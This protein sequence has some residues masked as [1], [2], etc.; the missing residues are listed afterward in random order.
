MTVPAC[1][2][3][4]MLAMMGGDPLDEYGKIE[5]SVRVRASAGSYFSRA[6]PSSSN[7]KTWTISWWLKP[8]RSSQSVGEVLIENYD[9]GQ[10][11]FGIFKVV[12]DSIRVYWAYGG[13]VL[14]DLITTR[15]FR[16]PGAHLNLEVRIDTTQATATDRVRVYIDGQQVT[17]FSTATY[18]AQNA[19]M[20]FNAAG[21][22][23]MGRGTAGN[24]YFDGIYSCMGFVDGAS[25][26]P[27]IF[28]QIHP[29]TG[30]WRP[31]SK[32]AIRAAVAAAGG[33]VRNGWGTNGFFLPFD[34]PT[35]LTT[36]GY[37]RSQSD[38]DTTGNNWA[39]T[40]ISLTAGAAYDSMLDT[41][42]NNFATLNPL[43]GVGSVSKII[44]E[45]NLRIQSSAG[46]SGF[47]Y[48]T[49]PIPTKGQWYFEGTQTS[50]NA[51]GNQIHISLS[52]PTGAELIAYRRTNEALNGVTINSGLVSAFIAA[53]GDVIGFAVDSDTG[54]V[55][56][57]RNGGLAYTSASLA[58][59]GASV[60]FFVSGT[61]IA[62]A[63]FGQ[64]QFAYTPPSGFKSLCT[65]NLP[66]PKIPNPKSAF[67]AVTDTGANIA[68]T[69]ANARAGWTAHIDIIKRRDAAEGWRWVF[70]DDT[71]NHLDSSSTAAKAPVPSFSGTAYVGYSLKVSA[72]NGVA[73]GR[74]TH[75]SGTVDTVVDGLSSARKMVILKNE[76]AGTWYVYHPALTVGKL[77]YLEQT[78]GETTD[79]TINTVTA[80]GFTV[81][82]ALAS[83]TYR[84][85]A[86]ADTDGLLKIGKHTGNASTDGPFDHTGMAP[87]IFLCKL[88]ANAGA[89]WTV[90]DIARSKANPSSE[91]LLPC[92][93]GAE[94]SGA[95]VDLLSNGAK[96]R[97]VSG[98]YN[99]SGGS[100]LYAA[101]AAFPFRY[102]NAR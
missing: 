16:D 91:T 13:N 82:A 92:T 87:G 4:L 54:I 73:T 37:D 11:H 47:G 52:S 81:A 50:Y 35:S 22:W 65:K 44:S 60:L 97:T 55:K 21:T 25:L 66:F 61:N 30:Q 2:N 31:K 19:E 32:A 89:F 17:S 59:Q 85:I 23:S 6:V 26:P 83:G 5:R 72:E 77:L 58:V 53:D 42:T 29:R 12:G 14:L 79:A 10:N 71:A 24:Q 99:D 98:N 39:A 67:V 69:L 27:S 100:Y 93:T 96:V 15:V 41:P 28:G 70:S 18:P 80:S 34:D 40:N 57:F 49:I 88:I 9:L 86:L 36:F 94:G 75:V 46:S 48:S 56:L 68:A 84:W 64:R 102:A 43:D 1:V 33:A 3:P 8:S 63:N 74:L 38:T 95:A 20:Y 101:F 7:R 76:A 78:A 62:T 45:G 51:T 90:N